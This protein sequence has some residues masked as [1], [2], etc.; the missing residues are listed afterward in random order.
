MSLADLYRTKKEEDS[1]FQEDLLI[2]I[3]FHLISAMSQYSYKNMLRM[4]M[5]Y[6][7]DVVSQTSL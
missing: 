6:F 5:V 3:A 7:T 4:E 1:E 2:E